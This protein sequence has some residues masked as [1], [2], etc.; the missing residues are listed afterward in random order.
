MRNDKDKNMQKSLQ[1]VVF[2]AST[3]KAGEGVMRRKAVLLFLLRELSPFL[4]LWTYHTYKINISSMLF[5][6][7]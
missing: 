6:L 1:H 7:G 3:H 5:V 4:F 2:Y